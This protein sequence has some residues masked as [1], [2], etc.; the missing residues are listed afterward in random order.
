MILKKLLS[1]GLAGAMML[2]M[3]ATAVAAPAE[4]DTVTCDFVID[5]STLMLEG[6]AIDGFPGA[7]TTYSDL[8]V[9]DANKNGIIDVTDV[10][11]TASTKSPQFTYNMGPTEYGDYIYDIGNV[12][13]RATPR[14]L[15]LTIAEGEAGVQSGWTCYVD[16][17]FPV[18]SLDKVPVKDGQT[19]TFDFT[20]TGSYD[21]NTGAYVP[22]LLNDYQPL[23]V[24]FLKLVNEA[25]ASSDAELKEIGDAYYETILACAD[26]E[27]YTS[28]FFKTFNVYEEGKAL[29]EMLH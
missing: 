19:V 28:A 5:T 20:I 24:K 26:D 17:Y 13:V 16:D 4:E 15:L 8:S 27:G 14:D 7:V 1:L 25:R 23:D 3:A 11:V 21:I 22:G 12:G 2:G 29:E 6:A 10:M 18:V 9:T